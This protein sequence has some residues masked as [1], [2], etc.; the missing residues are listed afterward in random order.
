[1]YCRGGMV[2]AIVQSGVSRYI[3]FRSLPKLY[4]SNSNNEIIQVRMYHYLHPS[5]PFPFL[6]LSLPISPLLMTIS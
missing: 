1:M 6:S 2:D 4:C 3:E 5:N